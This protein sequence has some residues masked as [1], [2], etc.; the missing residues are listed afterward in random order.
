MPRETAF[1]ETIIL[2]RAR[3]L[4]WEKGYTAT[5]IQDL[6]QA[7]GIRRS[8]IYNTFGGKRQLYDR[9]LAQYQEENLG[10]AAR[11]ASGYARPAAGAG[12]ALHS[13]GHRGAP[14][15]PHL[16]PAAVTSS[17]L[18]PRWPIPAPMR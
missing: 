15:V 3:D 8:S 16:G 9:T 7:L 13:G 6:E 11:D 5:S 10:P 1:D 4:F 18:P 2:E 17:M 14:R 12:A